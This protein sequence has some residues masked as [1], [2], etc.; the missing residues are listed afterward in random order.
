MK[1]PKTFQ[2]RAPL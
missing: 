2:Q 1:N